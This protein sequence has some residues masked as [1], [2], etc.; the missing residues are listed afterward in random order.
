MAGYCPASALK[1]LL[2]PLQFCASSQHTCLAYQMQQ[3]LRELGLHHSPN[4]SCNDHCFCLVARS[5]DD[6][7]VRK[8]T[9]APGSIRPQIG[10]FIRR[11][12]CPR[13]DWTTEMLK[14]CETKVD[15]ARLTPL[16]LDT[17]EGVQERWRIE[18]QKLFS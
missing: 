5:P 1:L 14:I 17:T 12:G 15:A 10:R 4:N 3:C 9:F 7:Q 2:R 11:V 16:L 18:L 6:A 13:Q 8:D